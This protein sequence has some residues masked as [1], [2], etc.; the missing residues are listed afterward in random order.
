MYYSVR[1]NLHLTFF[2]IGDNEQVL[3]YNC[4]DVWLLQEEQQI[5][6]LM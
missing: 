3:V 4:P 2:G 6:R 1:P 5:V